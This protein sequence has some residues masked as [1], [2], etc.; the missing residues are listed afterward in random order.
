MHARMAA[1]CVEQQHQRQ[2]LVQE[3]AYGG[4][5][6]AAAAALQQGAQQQRA[7]NSCQ[8][9]N[10]L[11]QPSASVSKVAW[12]V[13][14]GTS[15]WASCKVGGVCIEWRGL[16]HVGSATYPSQHYNPPT[17]RL[18]VE[19]EG[20]AVALDAQAD[21]VEG[22][23]VVFGCMAGKG[24]GAGEQ[25]AIKGRQVVLGCK[26]R[27]EGQSGAIRGAISHQR[28]DRLYSWLRD[29]RREVRARGA[30]GHLTCVAVPSTG[31]NSTLSA[32]A[33]QDC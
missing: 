22:G 11:V 7:P 12:Y 16:S 14:S 27:A 29:E 23:Q 9:M 30:R 31:G 25:S 2:Q 20:L 13:S 15:V 3:A 33:P 5:F 10:T 17:H 28:K 24:R 4:S 32:A 8:G 1:L 19:L 6:A 21:A 18:D 26:G